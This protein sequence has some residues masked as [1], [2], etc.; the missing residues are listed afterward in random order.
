MEF[1]PLVKPFFKDFS[2]IIFVDKVPKYNTEMRGFYADFAPFL[3]YYQ[4]SRLTWQRSSKKG[5][6]K[7]TQVCWKVRKDDLQSLSVPPKKL[8]GYGVHSAA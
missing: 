2:F 7:C 1:V 5:G 3:S 4:R 6:K 8:Q